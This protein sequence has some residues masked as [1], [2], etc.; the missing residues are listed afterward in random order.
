[1]GTGP[2]IMVRTPTT[3]PPTA[4]IPPTPMRI[5]T[6]ARTTGTAI[7]TARIIA[8]TTRTAA[9]IIAITTGTAA[10]ITVTS[11]TGTSTAGITAGK[12]SN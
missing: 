10:R 3:I 2:R 11:I 6:G 4:T 9:R 8:I 12:P 7:A 5:R 1:M